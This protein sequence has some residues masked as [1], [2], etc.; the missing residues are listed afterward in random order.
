LNKGSS[1]KPGSVLGCHLSKLPTRGHRPGKP[2]I[3]LLFGI[4]PEGG[5]Q[6]PLSPVAL[7]GSYPTV[8]L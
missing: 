2:Y 7:V 1:Y 5:C 3:A 4:A 8:S 6:L